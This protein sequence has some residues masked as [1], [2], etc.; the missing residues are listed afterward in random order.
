M[1]RKAPFGKKNI[2]S[3]VC[4]GWSKLVSRPFRV[5]SMIRLT[6]NRQ[7]KVSAA[8]DSCRRRCCCC[9]SFAAHAR[10]S[11]QQKRH[12]SS[13]GAARCAE[14]PG[15]LLERE[16]GRRLGLGVPARPRDFGQQGLSGSGQE[17]HSQQYKVDHRSAVNTARPR[18]CTNGNEQAYTSSRG[19]FFVGLSWH[20]LQQVALASLWPVSSNLAAK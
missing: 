8:D 6:R 19:L 14:G 1:E 3:A 5:S 12:K 9:A 15:D 20:A 17:A 13:S 11:R 18:H 16:C 7:A 10:R 2:Y 4:Q